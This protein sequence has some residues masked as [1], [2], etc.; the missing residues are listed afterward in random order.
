MKRHGLQ[1]V[2]S[3]VDDP[4]VARALIRLWHSEQVQSYVRPLFAAH[5]AA[6]PDGVRK[7]DPNRLFAL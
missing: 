4:R 1:R 2:T 3:Y 5:V 7:L 6:G